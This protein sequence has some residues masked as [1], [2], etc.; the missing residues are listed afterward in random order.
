MAENNTFPLPNLYGHLKKSFK[1]T[2]EWVPIEKLLSLKMQRSN[3][4]ENIPW[5]KLHLELIC[6]PLF[7][8]HKNVKMAL[9]A[10]TRSLGFGIL[11]QLHFCVLLPLLQNKYCWLTDSEAGGTWKLLCYTTYILKETKKLKENLAFVCY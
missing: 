10:S 3:F 6:P 7:L 5:E 4:N 1:F 2:F 11:T 8:W 9:W